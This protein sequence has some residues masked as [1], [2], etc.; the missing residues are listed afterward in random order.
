MA[1]FVVG[2][3]R[4]GSG[5]FLR[6]SGLPPSPARLHRDRP[7]APRPESGLAPRGLRR[8]SVTPIREAV[9]RLSTE[10]DSAYGVI[11]RETMR[12]SENSP[13]PFSGLCSFSTVDH[14]VAGPA[15]ARLHHVRRHTP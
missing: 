8:W 7:P 15:F 10:P 14:L 4:L 9:R 6:G 2:H 12:W 1:G 11:I 3:R 5:F 13:T